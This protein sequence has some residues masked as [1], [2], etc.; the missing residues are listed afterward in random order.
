MN[1]RWWLVFGFSFAVA[2]APLAQIKI[3]SVRII[4]TNIQYWI[5]GDDH[6]A[7]PNYP[8]DTVDISILSSSLL[9]EGDGRIRFYGYGYDSIS[10]SFDSTTNRLYNFRH[11][12][13][14]GDGSETV[15]VF[16]TANLYKFG[17]DYRVLM[18][19]SEL[20]D[21]GFRYSSE[22]TIQKGQDTFYGFI[23][24]SAPTDSSSIE[25]IFTGSIPLEVQTIKRDKHFSSYPNPASDIVT[26][27]SLLTNE[28]FA[29]YDI[30]GREYKLQP[31]Y[32][33]LKDC[34]FDVSHLPNG[35]YW[36][37]AGSASQKLMISK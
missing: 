30:T 5:G 28:H 23:R 21:N 9:S 2:S 25:V 20:A 34:T 35:I 4:K 36:L 17:T 15:E 19:G 18:R 7:I 33:T 12:I 8:Q 26:I 29:L 3:E 22:K 27:T 6:S 24:S 1:N 13:S 10:F 16:N 31:I 14:V 32:S 11:R 37:Q